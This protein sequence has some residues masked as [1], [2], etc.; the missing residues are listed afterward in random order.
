MLTQIFL[1]PCVEFVC[2]NIS[3]N[4]SPF[5]N[6]YP[7]TF[8]SY[9]KWN[10]HR[11]YNHQCII[12]LLTFGCLLCW[13]H[14]IN[15]FN[16]CTHCITR[17]SCQEC[18]MLIPLCIKDLLGA[19]LGKRGWA[20]CSLQWQMWCVRDKSGHVHVAHCHAKDLYYDNTEGLRLWITV[21]CHHK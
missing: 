4:S 3:L 13:W 12:K 5:L 2:M 21:F 14:N 11:K 19:P 15:L 16:C 20:P 7:G 17:R 1:Y 6:N 8:L 9:H 10:S 18:T